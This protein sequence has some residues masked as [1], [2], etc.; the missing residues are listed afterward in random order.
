MADARYAEMKRKIVG[1]VEEIL[2]LYGNPSFAEVVTNDPQKAAD[3]R[4]RI[5][6]STSSD[7]IRSEVAELEKRRNDMLADI[8]LREREVEALKVRAARLRASLDQ[9]AT[10]IQGAQRA[11]EANAGTIP[12]SQ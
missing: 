5:S 3:L 4:A 9:A 6:A 7:Q 11:M 12:S 2:Q 8:A 10:A 1:A